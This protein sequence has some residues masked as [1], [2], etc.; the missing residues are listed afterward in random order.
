MGFFIMTPFLGRAPLLRTRVFQFT[1]AP[2]P[3]LLTRS[4]L[5]SPVLAKAKTAEDGDKP[6]ESRKV[7]T[8]AKASAKPKVQKAPKPKPKP[9]VGK[10][11]SAPHINL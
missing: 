6:D 8:K 2:Y 10:C 3:V 4:L 7:K 11:N 9:V 1:R 5:T